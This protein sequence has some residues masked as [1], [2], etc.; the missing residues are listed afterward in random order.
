MFR[1]AVRRAFALLLAICLLPAAALGEAVS[2]AEEWPV[3][4]S[5][6]TRADFDL[7]VQLHA[8]AF[9]ADGLT[10][11]QG[12]ETLLSKLRLSGVMDLQRFPRPNNR[13]YMDAQIFLN[14]R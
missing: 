8:D 2:P 9:P 1:Q 10:D 12:W 5:A 6:V 13:M 7:S 4:S 14:D 11:Y 3:D